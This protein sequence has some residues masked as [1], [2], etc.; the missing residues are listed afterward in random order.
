[1]TD[2]TRSTGN[3][4]DPATNK[5][6][7]DA[8]SGHTAAGQEASKGKTPEQHPAERQSNYGGGGPNGGS[9]ADKR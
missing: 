8:S 7:T 5:D 1:M 9:G 2:R 3:A 4:G 6:T